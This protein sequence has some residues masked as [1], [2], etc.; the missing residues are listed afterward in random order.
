MLARDR[1]A[2]RG[3]RPL[4]MGKL[5]R[6]LRSGIFPRTKTVLIVEPDPVLRHLEE[7]ALARKYKILQTS[8]PEE[9]VRV[10][11][12]HRTKLDLLLTTVRFPH[13]DGWEL[14]ELLKLDY[15]KLKAIYVSASMETSRGGTHPCAVIVLVKDQFSANLL[16]QAVQDT[17]EAP[18]QNRRTVR[19]NPD[20]PF[21]LHRWAKPPI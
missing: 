5:T 14:T 8:G 17:L 3:W 20:S 13:M 19:D 6:A 2:V 7:S 21:S 11:A 9:A 16:L 18:T 1:T 4:S 15:P 10:A 12:R